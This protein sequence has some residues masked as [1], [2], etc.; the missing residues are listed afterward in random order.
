MFDYNNFVNQDNYLEIMEKIR[1]PNCNINFKIIGSPLLNYA[2]KNG[3]AEVIQLLK[4]S[5]GVM[6]AEYSN[7]ALLEA[8]DNGFIE[9]VE[10]LME[11]E[12]VFE[13][14]KNS[15]VIKNAILAGHYNIA[16]FLFNKIGEVRKESV[17]YLVSNVLLNKDS[18]QRTE[19]LKVLWSSEP[20]KNQLKLNSNKIYN[21][22]IQQEIL[23]KI[24]GF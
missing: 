4:D 13:L 20:I 18:V 7:R 16:L 17:G 8:V 19:L 12:E 24:N 22:M 9:I 10:K 15:D 11:I 1:S 2:C 5:N 6:F 14:S 3:I 23:W 21:K